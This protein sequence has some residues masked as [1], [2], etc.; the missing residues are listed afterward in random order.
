MNNDDF[1]TDSVRLPVEIIF[2]TNN[3]IFAST[4]LKSRNS[5]TVGRV[6]IYEFATSTNNI[7]VEIVPKFSLARFA[8]PPK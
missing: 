6:R 2:D 3:A 7:S 5:K 8:R 4:V 1:P